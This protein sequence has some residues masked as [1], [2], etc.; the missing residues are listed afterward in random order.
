M[1]TK[2]KIKM[3]RKTNNNII[4]IKED[5]INTQEKNIEDVLNSLD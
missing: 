5:S 4:K 2:K 3:F 1:N